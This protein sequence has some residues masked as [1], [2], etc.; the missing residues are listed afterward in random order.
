MSFCIPLDISPKIGIYAG[1]FNPFHIGHWAI[2]QQAEKV[3]DQIIIA[4]GQ[5]EEKEKNNFDLNSLE[6][7]QF[8]KKEK[9]EGGLFD[10][11]SKKQSELGCIS[12]IRGLRNND[13]L[14][15]ETALFNY[16]QDYIDIPSVY[17]IAKS[18]FRHISSGAIRTLQKL[19]KDTSKYLIS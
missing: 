9:Y 2:I 16:Q 17:F 5:N 6:T 10:F 13:D 14:E 18:E 4:Q 19:G 8:Y 11:L 1:S 15:H 3:F 7:L 12:L